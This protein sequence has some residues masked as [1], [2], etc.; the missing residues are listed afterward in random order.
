RSSVPIY[1]WAG[2]M[3]AGVAYGQLQRFMTFKNL[4]HLVI[5]P[6]NHG[7]NNHTD[8]F[9]PPETGVVPDTLTQ[10]AEMLCFFDQFVNAK[11]NGFGEK[12]LTYYTMN[13]G[14]WKTSRTWPIPGATRTR[15]YFAGDGRLNREAP[16]ATSGS[17]K[18]TV[19]FG[20]HTGRQNRWW[21]QI[22]GG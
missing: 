9:L 13:E 14:K 8:P 19:D 5:G 12:L 4:Q 18:Y 16:S 22:G 15:W 21:T 10:Y 7:M 17:D 11:D 1:A 3:D 6:W 2:W 20:H